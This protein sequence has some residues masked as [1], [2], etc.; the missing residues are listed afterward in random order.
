MLPRSAK[1][2]LYLLEALNSLATS[3]Y[4]YY[5]F[6]Y[7]RDF[8]HF[9]SAANLG[10]CSLH[11]LVYAASARAGGNYGQKEGPLKAL[12]LGFGIMFSM[13]LWGSL[14]PEKHVQLLVLMGWTFGMSF[15][16]PV[17]AGAVCQNA[18]SARLP[19]LV[20]IY[21]L[22]WAG[23]SG[24]SYFLGGVVFQALGPKSIFFLPMAI[25]LA[26]LLH[27]AF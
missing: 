20:G 10:V 5:L 25:H 22:V 24:L 26:Q 8:F 11:G 3:Y 18:S 4:F 27:V 13:L 14:I 15:T 1:P 2:V 9:S 19:K 23:V 21:N 7:T 17:L 12:R 6:F 16:W